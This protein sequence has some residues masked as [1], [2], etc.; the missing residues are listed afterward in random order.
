[1]SVRDAA[2]A[3]RDLDDVRQLLARAV[4]D[5]RACREVLAASPAPKDDVARRRREL[6]AD[7]VQGIADGVADALEAADQM[8]T[9]SP[10][11][12]RER[13]RARRPTDGRRL[14]IGPR[15]RSLRPA[16]GLDG[17]PF[18]GDRRSRPR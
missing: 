14:L 17:L 10:S 11:L 1:M 12:D 2:R 4:R 13:E 7:F 8:P 5:A 15:S 18:S 6:L 3:L 16:L 9:S